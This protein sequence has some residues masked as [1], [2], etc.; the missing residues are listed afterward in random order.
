VSLDRF[1]LL[2]LRRDDGIQ[3]YHARDVI[4]SRPVQV[5]LFANGQTLDTLALLAKVAYLPE[6][7][8]R[9]II[10]RGMFQGKPYVVT[11]RLAG[12]ASLREWLELKTVPT[13][14]Q[15]FAQL[16]DAQPE[17]APRPETAPIL[18]TKPAE[19]DPTPSRAPAGSSI[20]GL[21]LGIA[22]AILFLAILV[23]FVIF[24]RH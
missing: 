15:Q 19:P 18:L 7:D 6:T 2:E 10:D 24:R 8:R 13:V 21:T 23:A 12:F 20:L 14:D 4:T 22:A 3:T 9:R 17:A 5:H 11:D 16:F 1:E